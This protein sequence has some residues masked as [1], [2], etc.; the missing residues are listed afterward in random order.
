MLSG[1]DKM[2]WNGDQS[3]YLLTKKK[4][5]SFC[6]FTELS[7]GNRERTLDTNYIENVMF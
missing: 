3:L 2:L 7:F 5:K 4:K 6:L 1:K